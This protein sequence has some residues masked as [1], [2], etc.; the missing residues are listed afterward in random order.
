MFRGRWLRLNQLPF[1]RGYAYKL[2]A[3]GLLE[4]VL[5]QAP[6]AKKGVR[7]IDGESLDAYLEG[8]AVE[9]RRAQ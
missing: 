2:L 9:Q 7:L 6:G 5:V 4:S 3:A 1:S 8:L